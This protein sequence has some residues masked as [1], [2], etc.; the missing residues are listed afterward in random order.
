LREGTWLLKATWG[1]NGAPDRTRTC[2]LQLRRLSLYP[3]ELRAPVMALEKCGLPGGTRTPDPRLRRPPLY[4]LS[5]RQLPCA[6]PPGRLVE[7]TFWSGSTHALAAD[8][9]RGA[10]T[11]TGDPLLPKQVRYQTALRPVAKR[12]WGV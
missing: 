11:R 8:F 4:P 6:V 10:Q 1:K 3:A 2:D 9:Y 7:P 5:Y 12:E